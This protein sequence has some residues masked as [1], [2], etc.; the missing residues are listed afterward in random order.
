[1]AV[2]VLSEADSIPELEKST[3]SS[4]SGGPN[5]ASSATAEQMSATMAS[6]VAAQPASGAG[7]AS[8]VAARLA[9]RTPSRS[10]ASQSALASIEIRCPECQ[11]L[12]S[13]RW[14]RLQPG[15]AFVCRRCS[16]HF[17]VQ[18]D[19]TLVRMVQ[20]RRG[21][22]NELRD[23]FD[24]WKDRRILATV[25]SVIVLAAIVFFRPLNA[26]NS[27]PED[28]DYPQELEP[29]AKLFTLAWMKGDFRT[30]RQLTDA[31]QSQEL[32][33][34]AMDNPAPVVESPATMERDATLNVEI[35][36]AKPPL[37]QVQVRIDGL[38][39]KRGHPVSELA[40]DWKQDGERWIFQPVPRPKI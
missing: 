3:S 17:A 27:I 15:K 16:C 12:N 9:S 29:R 1:M 24:M 40:L 28:P 14:E 33:L 5:A 36:K 30:L 7:T 22:W 32:H 2:A 26:D 35:V 8:G 25:A 34:W 18:S 6:V 38:Q 31:D 23:R 39:I 20:N 37:A 19:G 13:I 11:G 4:M 21:Q 10:D